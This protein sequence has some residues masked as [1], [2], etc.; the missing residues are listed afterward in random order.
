MPADFGQYL[1][2]AFIA[3]ERTYTMLLTMLVLGALSFSFSVL[4]RWQ[5][6]E[7]AQARE[8]E[9]ARAVKPRPA[10]EL[11]KAA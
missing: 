2:D 9:A 7:R 6:A 10:E 3:N 8:E 5:E 11:R 4:P 1:W